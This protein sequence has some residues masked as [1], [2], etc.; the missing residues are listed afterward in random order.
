M[1]ILD[2][3]VMALRIQLHK[4]PCP[5]CGSHELVPALQCDYYPDGCL[6]IVR[7]ETCQAQYH[8]DH[9]STP[10]RAERKETAS[11]AARAIIQHG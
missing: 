8:L 7:C 2:D 6:W 1:T 11:G 9:R 3:P 10:T 4:L 5:T